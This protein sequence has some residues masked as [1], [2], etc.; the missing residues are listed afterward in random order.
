M[1]RA[2]KLTIV[3]IM[4]VKREGYK[5]RMKVKELI[6]VLQEYNEEDDVELLCY[7]MDYATAE[8]SVE[9]CGNLLMED[10]VG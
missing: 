5:M 1:K 6:K 4:T 9:P 8:L 7:S 10:G 2:R 3:Y